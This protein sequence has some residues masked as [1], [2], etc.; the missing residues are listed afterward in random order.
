MSEETIKL[1]STLSES[2]ENFLVLFTE[3]ETI[4]TILAAQLKELHTINQSIAELTRRREK[5]NHKG[6]LFIHFN[7]RA[8]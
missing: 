4:R 1:Q 7:E 3:N 2:D 5:L 8:C 6:R